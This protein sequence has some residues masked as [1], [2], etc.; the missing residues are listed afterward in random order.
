MMKKVLV[1]ITAFMIMFSSLAYA[2]GDK[3]RGRKGQGFTGATG[4]GAT[5]QTRGN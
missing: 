5:T 2:G 1:L 3:I 4:G